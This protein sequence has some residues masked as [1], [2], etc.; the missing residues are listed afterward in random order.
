MKELIEALNIFVEYIGDAQHP[1]H[2]E[3]DV[4]YVACDPGK[5]CSADIKRLAQLS[6]M[7]DEFGGF[8]SYK[9]GSC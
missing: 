9:F 4:L 7:P 6:F 5:V 2:C 3:H 8:C 1:T